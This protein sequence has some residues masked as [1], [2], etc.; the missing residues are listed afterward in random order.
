M[1]V[2][3]QAG[4]RTELIGYVQSKGY[5]IEKLDSSIGGKGG[6]RYSERATKAISGVVIEILFRIG[7]TGSGTVAAEFIVNDLSCYRSSDFYM[8]GFKNTIQCAEDRA[9]AIT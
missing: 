6:I 4:I 3:D 5:S 2:Q 8:A 9:N 1:V 7:Y